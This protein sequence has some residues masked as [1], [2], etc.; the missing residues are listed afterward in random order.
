MMVGYVVLSVCLI[1][2]TFVVTMV[3]I[4]SRN[5]T[6]NTETHNNE[7]IDL[8]EAEEFALRYV[9][10]MYDLAY[11]TWHTSGEQQIEMRDK[12]THTAVAYMQDHQIHIIK[13]QNN[14]N[15]GGNGKQ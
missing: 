3:I 4:G 6:I 1:I 5:Q 7:S 9:D 10:A 2:V 8:T 15:G 14:N 13:Q 12:K 11:V